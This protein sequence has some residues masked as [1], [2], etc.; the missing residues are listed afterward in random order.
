MYTQRLP[1]ASEEMSKARLFMVRKGIHNLGTKGRIGGVSWS[2][3]RRGG[4]GGIC[5]LRRFG[6]RSKVDMGIGGD[7]VVR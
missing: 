6:R 3:L 2:R 4:G 5:G 7:Y 1:A